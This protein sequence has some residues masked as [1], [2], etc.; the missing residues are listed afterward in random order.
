MDW[1]EWK[2]K[3]IFIKTKTSGVYSGNVIDIDDS[4][5]NIIFITLL[6]KFGDRVTIVHSE[7][8]KILEEK[9]G[10]VVQDGRTRV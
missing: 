10:K 4:N 6:D 8:L 5:K 9:S 2:N 7:I 1:K 3:K